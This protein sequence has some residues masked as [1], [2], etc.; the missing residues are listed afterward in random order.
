MKDTESEDL[1]QYISLT[2]H[3]VGNIIQYCTSFIKEIDRTFSDLPILDYFT[4]GDT[5]PQPG[6]NEIAY[7][8]Q[9]LRGVARKDS[10]FHFSNATQTEAFW[11]IKSFLEKSVRNSR[12]RE[13]V[14][15][16][17]LA[18][19]EGDEELLDHIATLRTFV[20]YD[21]FCEYFRIAIE[22]PDVGNS[23]WGYVLPCLTVVRE[24]YACEFESMSRE[25][26]LRLKIFMDDLIILMLTIHGVTELIA[27]QCQV[28]TGSLYSV[29]CAR[30]FD[31]VIFV[32][33]VVFYTKD[34]VELRGMNRSRHLIILGETMLLER[35]LNIFRCI[36]KGGETIPEEK[37][38]VKSVT[39]E[40]S[41]ENSYMRAA[42]RREMQI[43][44]F[45]VPNIS[46]TKLLEVTAV[47]AGDNSKVCIDD[48]ITMYI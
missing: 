6:S 5:F 47:L 1:V 45:D 10:N 17:I 34:I 12:E 44:Q 39:A 21:I 28:A 14:E 24:L 29:V 7:A 32:D 33:H 48:V 46:K 37:E 4:N 42:V 19:C 3:V 20:I 36:A 22:A 13:F 43:L 38:W 30:M 41:R 9:R 27:D 26:V 40:R 31:F 16:C 25:D 18:L 11:S 35:M 2:Q 8:A 15:F 23:A